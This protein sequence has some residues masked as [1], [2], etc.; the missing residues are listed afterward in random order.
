[1]QQK[2]AIILPSNSKFVVLLIRSVH[3]IQTLHG[4]VQLTLRTLRE[5]FWVIHAR[6]QVSKLI[7]HCIVCYR[8]KKLLLKQQ[9]AELP[10]FRT[11]QA[12]PFTSV[13]VDFAGPYHTKL[14]AGRGAKTTKGYIALFI[15]L[16]TKAIHLELV[17]DMSTA[18]FVMSLENF[19]A[20]RGIPTTIHSD[21]GTNFRGAEKEIYRLHDEMLS[22][23]NALTRMLAS[24][25]I[26]FKRIPATASHMAGIWERAVG[27]VK[28]HLKRVLKDTKLPARQFD[29]VL[30]QVECCVNSR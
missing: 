3:E 26:T 29:H 28:Y 20:R 1:M 21:N 24:K 25:R 2:I 7:G 13:G 12:R 30:K 19:I 14:N 5:H 6:R 15:C 4:G 23:T 16:T 22:Q 11:Q 17:P 27:L 10:S 18:E 9:M 8:N